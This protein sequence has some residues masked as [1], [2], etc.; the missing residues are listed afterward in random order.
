MKNTTKT[1]KYVIKAGI[2]PVAGKEIMAE[3]VK[4]YYSIDN[5]PFMFVHMTPSGEP[6]E[7]SADLPGQTPGTKISY[8][9]SVADRDEHL[10][11]QPKYAPYRTYDFNVLPYRGEATPGLLY[12]HVIFIVG[13][14]FFVVASAL[15]SVKY[16]RTG[17]GFNRSLQTAGI[18]TGMIFIGGFPLGFIIAYQVFGTPWTG[19]P[20][21]WDITDNKTLVIFL[22][23][24][25]SLFLVRGSILTRFSVGKGRFCP[26]RWLIKLINKSAISETK[27]RK[28]KISH[29]R[30]AK[31]AIIGA[32]LTV[33]LYLVPH[34]LMVSPIFS[35]ALFALLIAIFIVPKQ[36]FDH[37]HKDESNKPIEVKTIAD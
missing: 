3:G 11:Q 2:Y 14:I 19:I 26:F 31:L 18:A 5:G 13:A 25:I 29:Q 34:S 10:T 20:F 23:W 15:Y 6:N 1:D 21:G 27:P 12:T 36:I 37:E 7:Y 24:G 9:I 28:D 22:Y 16:L 4:V 8:F 30:F 17:N 32:I 35:I 33:A